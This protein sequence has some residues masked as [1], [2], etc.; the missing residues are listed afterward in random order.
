MDWITDKIALGGF[1]DSRNP[2]G[3]DAVLNVA[4]EAPV[5]HDL[6]CLHL[7]IEDL[8]P[9]SRR[10]LQR[11]LGFLMDRTAVGHR[12]L[13]HCFAGISRSPAIVAAFLSSTTGISA[14]EALVI[15]QQKRWKADP[16][17]VVWQSI[18]RQR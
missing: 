14:D 7:K 4:A 5:L 18:Q 17:P 13:V 11:A 10:D 3:V 15:I 8:Q 9:I 6:P 12:V 2:E 16:D 1:E